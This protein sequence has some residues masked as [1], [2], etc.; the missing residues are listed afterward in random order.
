MSQ[1]AGEEA[2]ALRERAS[3]LADPFIADLMK[4]IGKQPQQFPERD[5]QRSSLSSSEG[6]SGRILLHCHAG[7]PKSLVNGGAFETDDRI[8]PSPGC[9]L[10][11]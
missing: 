3:R 7:C 4:L 2:Q 5:D 8:G 11:L 9:D 10:N 1:F 6:Q